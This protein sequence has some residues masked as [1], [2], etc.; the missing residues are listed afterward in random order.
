M[1]AMYRSFK[2][3]PDYINICDN[4]KVPLKFCSKSCLESVSVAEKAWG[5]LIIY[6]S[7]MR[8]VYHK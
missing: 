6:K 5:C 2:D 7:L 8:T 1:R 4:N 3:A